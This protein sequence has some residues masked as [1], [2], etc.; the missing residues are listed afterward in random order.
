MMKTVVLAD[1]RYMYEN[2]R[3][4]VDFLKSKEIL[5]TGGGGFLGYYFTALVKFLNNEVLLEGEKIKLSIVD[6]FFRG[7]PKWLEVERDLGEINIIAG[8]VSDV[9]LFSGSK[10][11]YIIHAASI[12]SP[13]FYR[14]FPV[15]TMKANISGL[16]GILDFCVKRSEAGRPVDAVMFFS[17][18]E[19]YGDPDSKNI[20][21]NEDYNGNVSPN[22]PRSCYD[23]SKRM[24]EALCLGYSRQ[25]GIKAKIARPFNNY[26]PG[27]LRGDGRVIADIAG[28]IVDRRDITLYSNGKATRTFCYVADAIVGYIKVL[29]KGR[30]GIPYN[31]GMDENEI[32]IDQLAELAADI[33][34]SVLGFQPKIIFEKSQDQDYLTHNPQRRMPNI[35]RARFDIGYSPKIGLSEGLQKT[36]RWYDKEHDKEIGELIN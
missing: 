1:L 23:E 4:E 2:L 27:L 9:Q 34:S 15:E 7:I 26:G 21:T 36:L 6:K 20:P 29:I 3:D 11:N 35:N 18:S 30:S 31:I 13:I 12:A 16:I 10:A 32:S 22:G 25:F 24:G 33:S 28:D 14:Q 5:L 19:I 8:D 17:S